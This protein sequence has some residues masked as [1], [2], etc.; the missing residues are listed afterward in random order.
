[1]DTAFSEIERAA[2]LQKFLQSDSAA[3][4]TVTQRMPGSP[5]TDVPRLQLDISDAPGMRP[6]LQ[7]S[8][9][10]SVFGEFRDAS[11]FVRIRNSHVERY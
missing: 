2:F 7:A 6:L 5:S 4:G 1:M 3:C 11:I 9:I 10:V 8:Q